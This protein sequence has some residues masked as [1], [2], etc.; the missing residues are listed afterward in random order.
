MKKIVIALG[1]FVFLSISGC[2]YK[3]G[4]VNTAQKSYLFFSGNV[5]NVEVSID[6]GKRFSVLG[7]Q[8]NQYALKPGKHKI[9]V[10]REGKIIVK[11][12]V[13]IGEDISKEIEVK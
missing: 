3:E 13:Y 1:L 4:T 12:E 9:E 11:R 8:K 7:G 10:Y 2:G 6:E 5:K